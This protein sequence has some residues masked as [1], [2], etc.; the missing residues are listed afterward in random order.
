MTRIRSIIS[1][2]YITV[3]SRSHSYKYTVELCRYHNGY[4]HAAGGGSNSKSARTYFHGLR[5]KPFGRTPHPKY[6]DF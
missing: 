2:I 3:G 5:L 4:Q 1:G 6:S